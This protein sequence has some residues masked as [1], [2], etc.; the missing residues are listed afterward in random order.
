MV[1]FTIKQTIEQ[2][3]AEVGFCEFKL[4]PTENYRHPESLLHATE[5][6]GIHIMNT[7]EQEGIMGYYDGQTTVCFGLIFLQDP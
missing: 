3:T 2:L 1:N 5:G 6:Y 4:V 7:M